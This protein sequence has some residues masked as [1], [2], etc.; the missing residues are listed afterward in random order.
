MRGRVAWARSS[1]LTIDDSM[2]SATVATASS[3]SGAPRL[4]LP[5]R[6][7]FSRAAPH[8]H[9]FAGEQGF[10]ERC[11]RVRRQIRGQRG[12]DRHDAALRNQ[13]PVADTERVAATRSR[14]AVRE[15]PR[16]LRGQA[17]RQRLGRIQA[18]MPHAHLDEAPGRQE[19][20]EH[21]DRIEIHLAVA[22]AACSTTLG[23][24]A[25]TKASATGTS[26]PR[27][28]CLRSRQAPARNGAPL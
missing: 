4:T 19:E 6:I 2:E 13:E 1:S 21:A 11:V 5:P 12:I 28:R 8:R 9:G 14:T 7:R 26:M 27:R 25:S 3:T 20:D 18:A 10:I 23:S 16:H 24:Q 15:Q 17:A 22:R